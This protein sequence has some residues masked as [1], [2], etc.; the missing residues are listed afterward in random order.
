MQ[1]IKAKPGKTTS[2]MPETTTE[3]QNDFF[4]V[5][6]EMDAPIINNAIGSATLPKIV[7]LLNMILGMGILQ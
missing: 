6:I 2:F 7:M 4:S 5:S 3:S 1:Y